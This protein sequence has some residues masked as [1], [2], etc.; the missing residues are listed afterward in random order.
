MMMQPG[1]PFR[2]DGNNQPA[3]AAP[4]PPQIYSVSSSKELRF[5]FGYLCEVAI[6]NVFRIGGLLR[7]RCL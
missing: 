7:G 4:A 5:S 2:T 3:R 1:Q 6:A